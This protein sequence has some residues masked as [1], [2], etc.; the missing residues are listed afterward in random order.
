M[1][2]IINFKFNSGQGIAEQSYY[3]MVDNEGNFVFQRKTGTELL[4]GFT[5]SISDTAY[6][7]TVSSVAMSATWSE[8]NPEPIL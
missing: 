4:A 2:R 1:C 5:Y 3:D 6:N 8:C 7:F